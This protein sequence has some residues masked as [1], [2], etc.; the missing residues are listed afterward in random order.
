MKLFYDH[1]IMIDEVFVEIEELDISLDEK[2][3]MRAMIDELSHARVLTKILDLLP[4]EHH[5]LFLERFHAAPYDVSHL[6]FLEKVGTG[7]VTAE[8]ITL[9]KDLKHEVRK[10]I[11]AHKKKKK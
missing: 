2:K 1:L 7:R 11:H 9:G 5:D 4:S 6:Q 10:T 8:L 3:E